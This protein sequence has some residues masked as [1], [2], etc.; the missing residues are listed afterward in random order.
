MGSPPR[1]ARWPTRPALR[2]VSRQSS[3]KGER[4]D[5]E[6]QRCGWEVLPSTGNFVLG[7]PPMPAAEVAAWLQGGGLIVS[8]YPGHPRLNDWLRIAVRSPEEDDRLLRRPGR[9]SL[10]A[11]A[12]IEARGA[13]L[14]GGA[15]GRQ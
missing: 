6:L 1:A 11:A 13:S 14:L 4:L 10:N 2:T 15:G 9:A 3:P 12:G 5:G 8:S 7:R